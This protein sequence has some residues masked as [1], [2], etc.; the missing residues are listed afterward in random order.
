MFSEIIQIINILF[1]IQFLY[2][3]LSI[4]LKNVRFFAKFFFNCIT[5][6]K[7]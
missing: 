6:Y 1:R 7:F 3:L 5:I 4:V 2:Y